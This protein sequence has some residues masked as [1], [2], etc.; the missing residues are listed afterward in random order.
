MQVIGNGF[1]AQGLRRISNSW[2]DTVALAAGVSWA[3]STS[4]A[5]FAREAALLRDVANSCRSTRRRLVFFSTASAG[6]YGAMDGSGREDRPPRPCSPYGTH[7]LALENALRAGGADYLIV[8]ASH[9]V[10]PGQPAHQLLPA[11]VRQLRQGRVQID[12]TATRDLI[13]IDDAVTI[14]DRLLGIGVRRET[15]NVASG[16]A[17]KV[18]SIV[19]HLE[20]RL[21]L[22][23][24]RS[25]R[26]AGSHHVI[27][28]E[29]LRA[30]VPEVDRMGFGP[31]YYRHVVDRFAGI[32]ADA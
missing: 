13:S 5:D 28:I 16:T 30:L 15:V 4:S 7:K 3:A 29:K 32:S 19:D 26:D 25:Y 14:I 20:R 1:L 18:E 9:L 8:R 21:G 12:R 17:V 24:D 10:G 31:Y 11:L 2:P 22:V 27:S 6:M 23:A